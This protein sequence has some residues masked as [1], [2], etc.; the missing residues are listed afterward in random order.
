[1]PYR[2]AKT[3]RLGL[4]TNLWKTIK[5]DEADDSDPI[6][7]HVYFDQGI[8]Q[9]G[10]KDSLFRLVADEI[11]WGVMLF[12]IQ[13]KALYSPYDGGADVILPNTKHTEFYKEKYKDW[14]SDHPSGL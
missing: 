10:S 5:V 2:N 7:C 9:P 8:W 14:L 4:Q 3:K 1:V 13:D 12:A 11:V 6:Y